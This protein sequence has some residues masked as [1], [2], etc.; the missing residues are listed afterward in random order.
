M[1][2]AEKVEKDVKPAG[3][4]EGNSLFKHE[5]RP[6]STAPQ[7]RFQKRNQTQTLEERRRCSAP[8]SLARP[9]CIL[10]K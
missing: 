2:K 4:C 1:E 10:Q 5:W 8:P 6:N 7:P 3:G 9:A